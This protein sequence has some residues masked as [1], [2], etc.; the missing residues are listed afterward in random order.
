M[1]KPITLLGFIAILFLAGS[2]FDTQAN[3][4][5][6]GNRQFQ[7]TRSPVNGTYTNPAFGV[8]VTIPD[9]WSGFEMK[10]TTGMTSIMVAPG[11]FHMQPGQRSPIS[12]MVSMYPRNSTTPAPQFGPR[13]MVQNETCNNDSNTTKTVNGMNFTQVIVNCSGQMTMKSEYD[14]TKTNSSYII[15][16]YRAL[17]N[18]L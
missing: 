17:S 13:N 14:V 4:Q 1:L 11:G 2:I 12:M 16:G 5:Y 7:G 6:Q 10:R 8:T 15:L 3:A 18:K 9:G